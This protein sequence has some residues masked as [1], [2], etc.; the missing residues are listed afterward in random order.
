MPTCHRKSAWARGLAATLAAATWTPARGLPSWDPPALAQDSP[1]VQ[2]KRSA[3]QQTLER[4]RAAQAEIRTL[5]KHERMA[6]RFRLKAEAEAG[7]RAFRAWRGHVEA[8]REERLARSG[9]RP[10]NL[11][12]VAGG[13]VLLLGSPPPQ[14][15]A[16]ADSVNGGGPVPAFGSVSFPRS[17]LEPDPGPGAYA[18]VDP[19]GDLARF[20]M[21]RG[22]L[23][24]AGPL[25]ADPLVDLAGLLACGPGFQAGVQARIDD[26][27][28]RTLELFVPPGTLGA[29]GCQGGGHPDQARERIK[30][31][32]AS[33]ALR[34]DQYAA[35]ALT[36]RYRFLATGRGFRALG[37]GLRA[38]QA[39]ALP[40]SLN[41]SLATAIPALVFAELDD[42]LSLAGFTLAG[43]GNTFGVLAAEALAHQADYLAWAQGQTGVLLACAGAGVPPPSSGSMAPPPSPLSLLAGL[44]DW[45]VRCPAAVALY[46]IDAS[47]CGGPLVAQLSAGNETLAGLDRQMACLGTGETP[48]CPPRL[49]EG[50][51]RDG[52]IILLKGYGARLDAARYQGQ[53]LGD[54]FFDA[55]EI[56]RIETEPLVAIGD[57]QGAAGLAAGRDLLFALGAAVNGYA[58]ALAASGAEARSLAAT[59]GLEANA[60]RWARLGPEQASDSGTGTG[61]TE[62]HGDSTGR[63]C[64][65]DS[66]GDPGPSPARSTAGEPPGLTAEDLPD[67]SGSSTAPA[68]SGA[69]RVHPLLPW[70]LVLALPKAGSGWCSGRPSDRA[71]PPGL[72]GPP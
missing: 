2:A 69:S 30:L 41:R 56:L 17:I 33:Q 1:P 53:V 29:G 5:K 66:S 37:L 27:E 57:V 8:R 54:G 28:A 20:D 72:A 43:A 49:Q 31:F 60:E 46:G 4:F 35:D 24:Q 3:R 68:E 67:A 9:R 12:L 16:Q 25:C 45:A 13:V 18:W 48:G 44:L 34:Y 63:E 22:A 7:Q 64:A 23:A 47:H 15:W 51:G 65:L 52:A 59:L 36:L 39:L 21:A 61:P 62:P 42:S 70:V 32:Q 40:R 10:R 6:R 38:G 19:S 11:L 71:G 58:Y 50:A 26:L 55:G 14:A